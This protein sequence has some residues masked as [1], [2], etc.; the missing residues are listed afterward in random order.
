MTQGRRMF[1]I[2]LATSIPSFTA[3]TTAASAAQSMQSTDNHNSSYNHEPSS[4]RHKGNYIICVH[5][6]VLSNPQVYNN[7]LYNCL[8]PARV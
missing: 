1:T 4:H 2:S 7:Q 6:R 8:P 5:S 3:V